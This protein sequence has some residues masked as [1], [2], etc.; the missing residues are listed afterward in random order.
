MTGYRTRSLLSDHASARDRLEP[1]YSRRDWKA[2]ARKVALG[3]VLVIF[4]GVFLGLGTITLILLTVG[5]P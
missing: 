2:I 3:I 4:L 5:R 1:L